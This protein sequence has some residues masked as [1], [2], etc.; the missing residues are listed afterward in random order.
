MCFK[1][2]DFLMN[3]LYYQNR[4]FYHAIPPPLR[5]MGQRKEVSANLDRMEKN[6]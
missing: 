1:R 4:D 2:I 3:L 5:S 6:T